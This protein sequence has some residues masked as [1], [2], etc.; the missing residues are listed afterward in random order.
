MLILSILLPVL[1]GL[2]ILLKGEFKNR[3]TLLAV[4]GAGLAATAALALGVV[5]SGET[6][7]QLFSFGENLD[8]YFH[9]DAMG[10][11]FAVVV[12]LAW[13]LSGIML[14]NI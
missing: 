2:G 7:L 9:V 10:K 6:Q 11:L 13:L 4:T 14:L 1:L 8:L 12:N 5:L 3:N